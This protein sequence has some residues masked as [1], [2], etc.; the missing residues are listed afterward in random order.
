MI[1]EEQ[2]LLKGIFVKLRTKSSIVLVFTSLVVN[3]VSTLSEKYSALLVQKTLGFVRY[4]RNSPSNLTA[5]QQEVGTCD[6]AALTST[7]ETVLP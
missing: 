3:T 5:F 6:S 2:S 7:F 1:T 4:F